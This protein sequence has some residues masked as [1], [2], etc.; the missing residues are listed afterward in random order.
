MKL[1]YI[2]LY[3]ILSFFAIETHAQQEYFDHNFD[4]ASY[5]FHY[6][7]S[8]KVR[9]KARI[10]PMGNFPFVHTPIKLVLGYSNHQLAIGGGLS[11]LSK[12]EAVNGQKEYNSPYSSSHISYRYYFDSHYPLY[13][14]FFQT[15]LAFYQLTYSAKAPR[16][17]HIFRLENTISAGLEYKINKRFYVSG[18]IGIGSGE[19]FFF[20]FERPIPTFYFSFDYRIQ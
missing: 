4:S 15:N 2:L 9:L 7:L 18:G 11:L 14:F 12:N 19:G 20:F 10:I 16:K 3:S 5:K 17:G 1:V 6:D 8:K 13:H